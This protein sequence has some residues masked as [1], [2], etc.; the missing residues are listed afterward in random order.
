MC[1]HPCESVTASHT[2]TETELRDLLMT[3][4]TEDYSGQSAISL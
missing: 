1:Y 4:F 3:H 2:K